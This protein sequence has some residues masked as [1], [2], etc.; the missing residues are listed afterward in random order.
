M[1][2]A[3][4]TAVAGMLIFFGLLAPKAM[5]EQAKQLST[6]DL[7]SCK[8]VG[9]WCGCKLRPEDG[10]LNADVLLTDKAIEALKK[11]PAP[12]KDDIEGSRK[13]FEAE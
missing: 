5:A 1:G 13:L 8:C 3:R 11:E 9:H 12:T 10:A 6:I 2:T 4:T 7:N